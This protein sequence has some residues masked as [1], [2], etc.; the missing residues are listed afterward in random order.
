MAF[1]RPSSSLGAV[2]TLVRLPTV[3]A[4]AATSSARSACGT[5]RGSSRPSS[6]WTTAW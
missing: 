3:R 2:F 6:C 5:P 1:A 4:A